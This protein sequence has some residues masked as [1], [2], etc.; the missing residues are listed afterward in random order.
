MESIIEIYKVESL[1]PKLTVA[2]P[3]YNSKEIAWVAL[4]SL[5]NQIDIN[6]NWE[7]IVYEE[8]HKNSVFPE[9]LDHYIEKL[10]QINCSR[11]V[12]ITNTEH[13]LLID[14]WISIANNVSST[15]SCFIL[16]AAD[17]YSPKN[18]L[19][20]SYQKI[21]NEDYDWYDQSKGY[22]YSFI[23][24]R[25][26][27]YDYKGLTNLNMALKPNYVKTLP[28]SELKK[29]IDG[30]IY[31]WSITT[32]K[33]SGKNFRRYFD[34]EL[35]QDSIDTHGFNN[36]SI[37]REN[38]FTTKPAIF[39]ETNLTYLDLE[40][41]EIVKERIKTKT[42]VYE[43]SII[44]STYKNVEYLKEC[45]DSI[46]KSIGIKNVEVLIGVDGCPETKEY[47]LMNS[48]PSNF[49]FF[50]FE[51]NN[52]PYI[53]F[54]SLSKVVQ[55]KRLL[56]FG[57]DDI[58][59]P[60]MIDDMVTGL[61]NY[62]CV[63]PQ[64]KN[65]TDGKHYDSGNKRHI[66]EGVFTIKKE[67][68]DYLNGFEPWMCGAD[69]DFMGRLYKQ[70]QYSIRT[71]TR[72]NFY[73]RIHKNGLTSR[74]DTGMGSKLRAHYSFLSRS[75]KIAGPLDIMVTEQFTEIKNNVIFYSKKTIENI[76]PSQP[77]NKTPAVNSI[78]GR[79]QTPV[80]QQR[81]E[82][83]K[84]KKPEPQIKERPPVSQVK[85][86]TEIERPIDKNS[87]TN[88]AKSVSVNKKTQNPKNGGFNIGKDSLRI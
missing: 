45:F 76:I 69:S 3:V 39:S 34:D 37:S 12:F 11:I 59:D 83:E 9:I 75:K 55:S 18:R 88:K 40:W 43:L 71:T 56:F 15:S 24:D 41:S 5:S 87:L 80:P 31:N 21:V 61:S 29:G 73:R 8:K 19:Q 2:L 44:I 68:F 54:N 13:I 50:N 52:G 22:F 51:K 16:H 82:I 60:N 58:M 36:I 63:K 74:P 86:E 49:K 77:I 6:F 25:V 28:K 65:F 7:L 38:Y 70:K 79:A 46:G 66:G 1:E 23:S 33:R 72:V 81:K 17:C 32:C 67:I 20:V 57:S 47:V 48:F 30:Y 27:L 26:F 10:K 42:D 62:D 84:P 53:V 35:Y 4:E 78:F 85:Q 14:K 64:Y